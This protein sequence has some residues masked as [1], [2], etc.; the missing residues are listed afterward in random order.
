MAIEHSSENSVLKIDLSMSPKE[1]EYWLG[2]IEHGLDIPELMEFISVDDYMENS[3]NHRLFFTAPD[4]S[5]VGLHYRAQYVYRRLLASEPE[6]VE[7]LTRDAVGKYGW[8]LDDQTK[9]LLFLA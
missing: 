5:M 3:N 7:S 8:E 9:E 4:T 6:F 2:E 1:R